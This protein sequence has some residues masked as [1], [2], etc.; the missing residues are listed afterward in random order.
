MTTYDLKNDYDVVLRIIIEP[1][2]VEYDLKPQQR[3]TVIVVGDS[4]AF[5]CKH[6]MDKDGF[7]CVAFWPERGSVEIH[8]DGKNIMD[9]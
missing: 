3:V 1:E 5:Q 4:P 6:F 9:V 7:H 2:A 8:F